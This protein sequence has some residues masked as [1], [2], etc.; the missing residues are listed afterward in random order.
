MK[1]FQKAIILFAVAA[2]FGC[3]LPPVS[4]P[5]INNSSVWHINKWTWDQVEHNWISKEG[6]SIRVRPHNNEKKVRGVSIVS[7]V[8]GQGKY[9]VVSIQIEK[10][11]NS[12]IPPEIGTK[13]NPFQVWLT[14]PDGKSLI[15]TGYVRQSRVRCADY[16]LYDGINQLGPLN[17]YLAFGSVDEWVELSG[18]TGTRNT[19]F[20][21]FYGVEPP[22]T[23]ITFEV[24]IRGLKKDDLPI[25][26]PKISFRPRN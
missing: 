2:S 6:I 20:D 1:C 16:F 25:I 22:S 14:L 19:C 3:S 9:F 15:P 11:E 18:E 21:L 24:E 23:K 13:F 12:L 5:F 26:V 8:Q 17:G 10:K 4:E 7:N